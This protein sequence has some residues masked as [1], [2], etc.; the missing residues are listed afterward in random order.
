MRQR[1]IDEENA[2]LP[3]GTRLMPEEERLQTLADLVVAKKAANTQ[4]EKLPIVAK[5]L[6]MTDH[7]RS[8]EEKINKL[9]RAIDTF[10]KQKV[11]VQM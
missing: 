7:K 1:F 4:L 10:S 3:P 11:Y 5:S 9:D 8:I 6:K 2:K